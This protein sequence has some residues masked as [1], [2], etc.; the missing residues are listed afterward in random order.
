ML[1]KKPT[2][3]KHKYYKETLIPGSGLFYRDTFP[4][5][6]VLKHHQWHQ[7]MSLDYPNQQHSSVLKFI[8]S[9]IPIGLRQIYL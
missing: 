6:Q 4:P 1:K 8:T 3:T 9:C 2:Q 5:P 7:L